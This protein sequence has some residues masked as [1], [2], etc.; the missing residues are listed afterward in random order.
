MVHDVLPELLKA[1]LRSDNMI[2]TLFLPD[3][4]GCRGAIGGPKKARSLFDFKDLVRGKTFQRAVRQHSAGSQDW[5]RRLH[6]SHSPKAGPFST[7]MHRADAATVSYTEVTVSGREALIRYHAGAPCQGTA[8]PFG[9]TTTD[10][11][12]RFDLRW[13][14]SR[15]N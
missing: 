14:R 1:F 13:R 2:E 11:S 9:D 7:C 10:A 6:R 3:S 8:C 12:L 15:L 5:L 4:D